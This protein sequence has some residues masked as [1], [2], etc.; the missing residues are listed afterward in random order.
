MDA[1]FLRSKESVVVNVSDSIATEVTIHIKFKT[2]PVFLWIQII[3]SIQCRLNTG[4]VLM[5]GSHF[6]LFDP[7]FLRFSSWHSVIPV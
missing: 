4:T 6:F 5:R 3:G 7:L 1:L 2:A